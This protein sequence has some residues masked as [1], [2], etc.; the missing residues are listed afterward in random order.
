MSELVFFGAILFTLALFF[1]SIGIW[2][3]FVG[4]QLKYWHLIMFLLGVITDSLGTWFMYLHV[5]HLIFTAHSISGFLGLALMVFHSIWA[6]FVL[7]NNNP[8]RQIIFHRFSIGVWFFW[9]LSYVSG[10]YLGLN[11]IV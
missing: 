3:D 7:L 9:L 8:S 4:K 5:G 2:S 10:A 6:F 11:S 1:Y